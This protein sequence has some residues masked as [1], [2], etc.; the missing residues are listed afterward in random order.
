LSVTSSIDTATPPVALRPAGAADDAFLRE[1]FV[2]SRPELRL[3][4]AQ[5]VDLQIAAQRTQYR[6]DHREPVEEVIEIDGYPVGRC[7]TAVGA[8]ELHLLDLAVRAD[9]RRQGIGRAVLRLVA[10]RAAALCVTVRLSVWSANGEAR[11]L[12]R[13]AGFT[14]TGAGGGYVE[15]RLGPG[16]RP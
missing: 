16:G 13:A 7:W 5:L 10:H 1:L 12:Y 9:R 6:R 2:D 3:L 4:P 14:E 8:G 11:R 15:M